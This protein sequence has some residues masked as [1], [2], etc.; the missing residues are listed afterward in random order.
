[1]PRSIQ[2]IREANGGLENLTDFEIAQHEFGK[3]QNYYES[4]DQFADDVGFDTGGKWGNR[5]SASVDNYQAGMLGVGEAITGSETLRRMRE[6]NELDARNSQQLAASQGAISSYKDVNSIGTGLDYLGGQVVNTLPYAAEAIVGGVLTG[7]TSLPATAARYGI[8][9]GAT[10]AIGGAAV[11]YPSAVGDILQSQRDQSGETDGVSAAIGGVGYAALNAIG[12]EGALARGQMFRSGIDMLDNVSGLKGL[13]ARTGATALRTAPVESATETGQEVINQYFG[14]MAVD[15]NATLTDPDAIDRYKES[16]VAGAAVGSATSGALGGW[17]RSEGYLPPGQTAD[18]PQV[19]LLGGGQPPIRVVDN[20]VPLQQFLDAQFGIDGPR[21][22]K[23]YAKQFEEAASEPSDTYV[24]DPETGVERRLDVL[25]D[26]N[27][28][29][30]TLSPQPTAADNPPAPTSKIFSP[31]EMELIEFGVV[32]TK[33]KVEMFEDAKASG[34]DLTGDDFQPFWAAMAENKLGNA[35]KMLAQAVIEFRKGQAAQ[36]PGAVRVNPDAPVAPTQPAAVSPDVQDAPPVAAGQAVTQA[37]PAQAPAPA[38]AG[39]VVAEPAGVPAAGAGASQAP[40]VAEPAVAR[41]ASSANQ[42]LVSLFPRNEDGTITVGR[43]GREK[44]LTPEQLKDKLMDSPEDLKLISMVLGADGA[45]PR[46][47]E[48]AARL[49]AEESGAAPKSRQRVQQ[50]LAD[51]GLNATVVSA[52]TAQNPDVV[53]ETELTAE[54][55]RVEDTAAKATGQGQVLTSEES[56]MTAAQKAQK[57]E[58]DKLLGGTKKASRRDLYKPEEDATLEKR[59]AAAAAALEKDLAVALAHPEASGRIADYNDTRFDGAPEFDQLTTAQ[60]LEYLSEYEAQVKLGETDTDSIDA[61]IRRLSKEYQGEADS[62]ARTDL[63][64]RGAREGQAASGRSESPRNQVSPAETAWNELSARFPM[65][66]D[67]AGLSERQ[68]KQVTDLVARE[69]FNLAAANTIAGGSTAVNR[70]VLD[71][72]NESEGQQQTNDARQE[73][74]DRQAAGRDGSGGTRSQESNANR[75]AT[76]KV[77]VAV[78]EVIQELKD[79]L[80]ADTLGRRV[81]VV[82]RVADLPKGV[83]I[84]SR[85]K[86]QG[87][88]ID[89]GQ[90]G[91]VAYLIADNLEAGNVRAVFMHEV[92]SHLGLDNLVKN[93][94]YANLIGQIQRWAQLGRTGSTKLEHAVAIRAAE[95]VMDAG[96]SIAPEDRRSELLAYFIEEAILAGVEPTALQTD[97]SSTMMAFLRKVLGL[98]KDIIRELG[99]NPEKITIQDVVDLAY[100]AA[101]LEM[102]DTGPIPSGDSL[103]KTRPKYSLATPKSGVP[104]IDKL[105][106]TV[107]NF[108]QGLKDGASWVGLRTMFT[109]DLVNLA[110]QRMPS[111]AKYLAEMERIWVERGKMEREIDSVLE[112]FRKL[113]SHLQGTGPGSVNALIK[114]STMERKWAFKPAWVPNAKVDPDMEARF[115]AMPPDARRVIMRVFEHGHNSLTQMKAAALANINSEYDDAIMVAKKAGDSAE[116]AK[117]EA[118]KAKSVKDFQSLMAINSG[119]PYAPLKRFGKYVVMGM[120]QA[121]YDARE[122]AERGRLRDDTGEVA[123]GTAE[124]RRLESDPAHYYV[125]FAET[126]AQARSM[127]RDISNQY[128]HKDHFEKLDQADSWM[129][130]RDVM[131]AFSRLRTQVRNQAE[132]SANDKTSKA[133]EDLLRQMYLTMLSENSVRKSEINRRN[134]AGADND[135]MRAFATQGKAQAH[136]IS[137]LK[138]NGKANDHLQGMQNEARDTFGSGRDKAQAISNEI[139]RR[140]AMALEYAPPGGVE[141]AMAGTSVWMLLTNPSYFLVNATQPWMM[142]HPMLAAKHGYGRSAAA[143]SKA[144][145]DILPMVKNLS[146][147]QEDYSKLPADVRAAV[148]ELADRG[149]IDISLESVLGNF[150]S[151]KD[152]AIDNAMEKSGTWMRN[153]AQFVEAMNRLSS[154]VAAYR[155]ERAAGKDHAA[156]VAYAGKVIYETHGDYSGF[157]SP[158]FMRKGFWKLATQFRKFQLIQISMFARY[159]QQALKGAT[160]EERLV[161]QKAI[162]Y[163]FTHLFAAGGLMGLPGFTAIAW[164]VGTLFGDDDEPKDPEATLRR[165]IG[166]KELADLLLKGAPKLAGVDVS[167]RIGA[168]GMLSILP[169]ADISFSREGY[170]EMALGLTGPFLGGLAPK[171]MDGVD[172]ISQGKYWEGMEKFAP[173]G[174][175]N[176]LTAFRYNYYGVTRRNGDVVLSPD[177][178]TFLDGV[179]KTLGLPTNTLTD[180][181]FL[182]N[183]QF[184]TDEFYRNRTTQLKRAYTEAVR[185]GDE[186][187]R[188]EAMQDWKD[189]QEA[190]RRVG[191]KTQPL[192]ELLKAPRE[193]AKRE[194]NTVAGVQVRDTN[195]GVI[196]KLTATQ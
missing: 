52:I 39:G 188:R 113:P 26:M 165:I 118:Q 76:K 123:A 143:L 154:A 90:N 60:K 107:G 120:S 132:N 19:D 72:P 93:E 4:F 42:G 124:M 196:E 103:T 50:I 171:A 108:F 15:P 128:A 65:M 9:R 29:A 110:K 45:A 98:F 61:L 80:R 43:K 151:V 194:R 157:N 156:G 155:L 97:R 82:Q 190:R 121:Y 182:S 178:L 35:K 79:F 78:K 161:A 162:V 183:T 51:Y 140:H 117:L 172:L 158:R 89:D 67:W 167:G 137:G 127:E 24:Q 18:D 144:Y 3:F 96:K 166:D 49:I 64:T 33:K 70:D 16:A 146:I 8:S 7:M 85:S 138:S 192:S 100:G 75:L 11:S 109:K 74:G 84:S 32:P 14:R 189:T 69:Q 5:L 175:A 57:K 186:A 40:V 28:R 36:A 21:A 153:S 122:R 23:D 177:E 81:V 142:T 48:D 139:A 145:K 174:L 25:E 116:L 147:D 27:L 181:Q 54:G 68:Q 92:G 95:R 126:K 83:K 71:S 12:I 2:A 105:P 13:A 62:Q 88:A 86:T 125:A 22:P 102:S 150:R 180:R 129:G 46:S 106:A 66:P 44:K 91:R 164:I 187:A 176:L 148:E 130:G 59:R 152:G 30:G 133:M 191:M 94:A 159:M 131:G 135:M 10:R 1:M 101:Q 169:Y 55:M 160:P 173:T 136:F 63:D 37:A 149:V 58:A 20:S 115:K 112:D 34:L 56:G 99:A 38:P 47:Y 87:V 168:G 185:S 73:S 184:N 111:A 119:W 41:P 170:S 104:A 31:V 193:Q 6:R 163:N 141:K 114:D 195:R 77:G 134:I 17:R 53:A 179:A